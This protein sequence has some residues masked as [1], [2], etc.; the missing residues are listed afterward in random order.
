MSTSC[1]KGRMTVFGK[2]VKPLGHRNTACSPNREGELD[3]ISGPGQTE[4]AHELCSAIPAQKKNTSSCRALAT[5]AFSAGAYAGAKR[6]IPACAASSATP[7]E[8]HPAHLAVDST[9]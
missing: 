3:D 5:T 7:P 2:R 6:S 9:A 4:A 1:R 8:R